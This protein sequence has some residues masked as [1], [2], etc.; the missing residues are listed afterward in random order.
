MLPLAYG[1]NGGGGPTAD[2]EY[3]AAGTGLAVYGDGVYGVVGYGVIG[4]GPTGDPNVA[5]GG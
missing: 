5:G 1:S 3:G 4:A 2:G